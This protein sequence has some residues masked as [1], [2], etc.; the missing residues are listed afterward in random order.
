M[1]ISSIFSFRWLRLA[2]L[3]EFE[4]AIIDGK[5]P[6]RVLFELEQYSLDPFKVYL[7]P[8]LGPFFIEGFRIVLEIFLNFSYFHI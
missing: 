2:P 5:P 6:F 8:E 7:L 1:W 3:L 4:Y